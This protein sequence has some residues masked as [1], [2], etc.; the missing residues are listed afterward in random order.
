MFSQMFGIVQSRI[1]HMHAPR[2]IT[3]GVNPLRKEIKLGLSRPEKDHP[4][5]FMMHAETAVI[6]QPI[7]EPVAPAKRVIVSRGEDAVKTRTVFNVD[8]SKLGAAARFEYFDCEMDI[9]ASNTVGRAL[10]ALT[11]FNKNP[12]TPYNNIVMGIR[13]ITSFL[14]LFP[15]AEKC[16]IFAG[17]SQSSE[18]PVR[19]VE[20]SVR[21][22]SEKKGEKL[23]LRGSKLQ[24]KAVLKAI[25]DNKSLPYDSAV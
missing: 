15:R 1:Y 12:K 17:Y 14:M 11:P 23:F 20:L 24:V 9:Q 7:G 4:N 3:A 2:E 10:Y 21:G 25:G 8:N 5:F 16:G 18:T 6:A 19:K 22:N 13:Q